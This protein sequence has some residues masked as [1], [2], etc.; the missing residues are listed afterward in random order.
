MYR[1]RIQHA[2]PKS[3]AGHKLRTVMLQ[4]HDFQQAT[5][6]LTPQQLNTLSEWQ[7]QRLKDSHHDLYSQS[8]Y[9]DGLNFLFQEL[10]APQDFSARD[11]DLERI[12]PKL[13]KLLPENV[14]DTVASLIELNLLT[15]ELDRVLATT[16]FRNFASNTFDSVEYCKAYRACQNYEQRQQQINLVEA[17][18]K[19]LDRYARSQMLHYSLK[20]S[21]KA[22]EMAD[23]AALHRFISNGFTA[24]HS[25]G[26]VEYLMTTL[27][28]RERRILDNIFQAKPDPFNYISPH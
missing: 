28:S 6:S 23:L 11:Q 14:L 19:K 27:A 1:D 2:N 17:V 21:R 10:Y 16:L 4:Y 9:A 24:F 20:L 8:K 3:S 18:A 26:N 15:Q 7:S 5:P 12:F 25:M 22:A 13:L